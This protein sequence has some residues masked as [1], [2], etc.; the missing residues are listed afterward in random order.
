MQTLKTE[1]HNAIYNLKQFAIFI[2]FDITKISFSVFA[3]V[4]LLGIGLNYTA[5]GIYTIIDITRLKLRSCTQPLQTL[6]LQAFY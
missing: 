3:L 2:R 6:A 4:I 5:V 1:A